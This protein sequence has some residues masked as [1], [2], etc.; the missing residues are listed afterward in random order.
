MPLYP[1]CD[2]GGQHARSEAAWRKLRAL[3]DEV[4]AYQ[5][6]LAAGAPGFDAN[7]LA[8]LRHLGTDL[9]RRHGQPPA[10]WTP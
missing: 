10:G 2:D 8:D 7:G 4:A 6:S 1:Q 5:A 9:V 3:D